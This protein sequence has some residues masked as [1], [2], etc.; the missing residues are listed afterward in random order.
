MNI[1]RK[2]LDQTNA[3][4]ILSIEKSDY[5]EKVD[6]KLREYRKKANIPGF[7]PGNVPLG[8]VQ[9]MYGKA[10]TAE[11]INNLVADSL[12]NY[13]RENNIGI[14]GEPLPAE[15]QPEIDFESQDAFDFTFDL[16][17]AP[18]FDVDFTS[19]DKVKYYNI[20]VS[21][22]MI[23]N[24]I[25]SYT[26]R[27]GKYEQEET[28]ELKDV[29]KGEMLE[30]TDGKVNEEG[31]KVQD[32]VLTPFYMKNE[33][34]KALFAGKKKGDK[35]VFNPKKAFENEAEISSLLKISKDQAKAMDADFQMEIQ[36][37]TR[38]HESEINQE[39][40]DKVFGDGAVKS[41]EEFRAKITENIKET[42]T[43][44]SDYK[45]SLDVRKMV[46]DKYKGLAFP[47]A[48]LK[49]WLL[50]QDNMTAEKLEEDYPKMISDVTWHLVKEKMA[51][52]NEIKIEPADIEAYAK[53]VAKAEFARYGMVG[54]EDAMYENYARDMMKKPETVRGFADR[55]I[56]EKVLDLLKNSVKLENTDISMEDF[57]KMFE[58]EQN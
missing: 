25:K 57:N 46:E 1:V 29:V 21:D 55:A 39:L 22:E 7:R 58:I 8:L 4:V 49:R 34:Q 11:E 12:Y 26:G 33:E 44:D 51:E 9:K 10:V 30:M 2:D 24:Q 52:K 40:F 17:I 13:I 15:N 28:V 48:F 36:N 18:P 43:E 16:G 19:K 5:A 54:M 14:L 47:D 45:F 3:Q 31:L 35:V 42:L 23:D 27:Y 41:E 20:A 56:E 32:A 53:K 6:K 38:Y 37:I 50:T